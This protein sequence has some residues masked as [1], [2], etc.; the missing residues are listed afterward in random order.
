MR[1]TMMIAMVL[2]GGLATACSTAPR[3]RDT[4]PRQN[5]HGR[6][7]GEATISV[8]IPATPPGPLTLSH[9]Q[10]PIP[11]AP[12]GRGE[13]REGCSPHFATTGG[14]GGDRVLIVF[15]N[16]TPFKDAQGQPL[17]VVQ[18]DRGS[19]ARVFARDHSEGVCTRTK[20]GMHEAQGCKYTAIHFRSNGESRYQPLDP[21][22]IIVQ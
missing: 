17:Y 12:T 3:D 15:E 6:P 18:A 1:K 9:G 16:D 22:I 8:H 2:A 7:C 21:R 4:G 11:D 5:A 19:S 13:V 10:E 20:H 14:A